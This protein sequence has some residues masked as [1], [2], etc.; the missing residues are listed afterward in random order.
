[1]FRDECRGASMNDAAEHMVTAILWVAPGIQ[2]I[3]TGVGVGYLFSL[4]RERSMPELRPALLLGLGAAVLAL[5]AGYFLGPV[6]W[7]RGRHLLAAATMLPIALAALGTLLITSA[8]TEILADVARSGTSAR[9]GLMF[10]VALLL[11]SYLVPLLLMLA[12]SS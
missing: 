2:T 6:W 11:L 9:I 4:R 12:A 1:M 8:Q 7:A 3:A 10:A 5:H